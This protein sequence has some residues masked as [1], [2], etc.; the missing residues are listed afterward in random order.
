VVNCQIVKRQVKKEIGQEEEK[1][2]NCHW[3]PK[4]Q[5]LSGKPGAIKRNKTARG[6]Q[7]KAKKPVNAPADSLPYFEETTFS[8]R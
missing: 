7:K 5:T 8:S 6:M 2:R 3:K 1:P 4:P